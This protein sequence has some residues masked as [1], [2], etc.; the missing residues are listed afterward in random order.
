MTTDVSRWAMVL[1][2]REPNKGNLGSSLAILKD[3]GGV[4]CNPVFQATRIR[5]M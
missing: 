3:Q 2:A 1:N 4:I 5:T